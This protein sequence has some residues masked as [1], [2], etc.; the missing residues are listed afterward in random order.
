MPAACPA[1]LLDTFRPATHFRRSSSCRSQKRSGKSSPNITT[2]GFLRDRQHQARQLR[3]KYTMVYHLYVQTYT[4]IH[5]CVYIYIYLRV[6]M[7]VYMYLCVYVSV[8]VVRYQPLVNTSAL[9]IATSQ[10]RIGRFLWVKASPKPRLKL[11]WMQPWSIVRGAS[12][13][14]KAPSYKF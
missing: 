2:L 6:C 1:D 13:W 14:K 7:S 8:S 5:I 3:N 9:A 10:A 12:T 4:H 11:F